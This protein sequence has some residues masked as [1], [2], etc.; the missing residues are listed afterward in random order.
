MTLPINLPPGVTWRGSPEELSRLLNAVWRNCPDAHRLDCGKRADCNL[1]GLLKS[2]GS[3]DHLVAYARFIDNRDPDLC[4]RDGEYSI[5][6]VL[7]EID[8]ASREP[9]DDYDDWVGC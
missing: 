8:E 7:R 6:Q 3:I 4:N 9:D 2:Q 1:C 5:G